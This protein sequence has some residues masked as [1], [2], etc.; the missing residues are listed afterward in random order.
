MATTHGIAI[1]A[2]SVTKRYRSWDM[3]QPERE[4]RALTLLAEHAPGLAPEPLR[5]G[6][7]ESPPAVTMSRLPGE[8]LS[9]PLTDAQFAALVEAMSVSQTA[10]PAA[11]LAALP[12][13][14]LHPLDALKNLRAWS[15]RGRPPSD[16]LAAE[17]LGAARGWLRRPALDAVFAAEPPPVFGTGDGNLANFLWDG[18]RVRLVDFEFSGR[19]DRAY[20]LAEV[21]EHV[22]AKGVLDPGTLLGRFELTPAERARLPECRRLLA[23]FWLLALLSDDPDR[24]RNPPGTLVHQAGHLL[25][26]L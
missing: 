3:A 15:E 17:A 11:V 2:A 16:A 26:L 7:A 12:S 23:V 1:G 5:D 20:E 21:A 14:L 25:T 18:S 6:T 9:A 24:P 19:G 8:P 4:W 13:R 10:I 22:S